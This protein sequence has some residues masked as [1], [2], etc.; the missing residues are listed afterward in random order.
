MPPVTLDS[1]APHPYLPFQ[2]DPAQFILPPKDSQSTSII[3]PQSPENVVASPQLQGPK[4]ILVA[5]RLGDL[6]WVKRY[7]KQG[8]ADLADNMGEVI[9]LLESIGC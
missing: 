8:Q 2:P 1:S 7:C 5:A 4:D 6:K 9:T 3:E